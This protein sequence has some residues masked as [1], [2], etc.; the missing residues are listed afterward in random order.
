MNFQDDIRP[1][2]RLFVLLLL[3]L[4][5][6][7][8]AAHAIIIHGDTNRDGRLDNADL[9]DHG[10]WTWQAGPFVLANLDDDDRNGKTDAADSVVNGPADEKDLARFQIIPDVD[11]IPEGA[12]LFLAAGPGPFNVFRKDGSRWVPVNAETPL[13]VDGAAPIELGVEAQTFAGVK[14]WTGVIRLEALVKKGGAVLDSDLAMARV[15]PWLMFPNSAPTRAFFIATGKYDNA[16]MLK[17]TSG[18]LSRWGV[19]FP[20]PHQ[21]KVWQ[22]MWMQDSLEIGY[23]E[24]PGGARMHVVLNGIRGADSFGPTLLAPD[25]GV[26][27]VGGNRGMKGHDAWVDWYGNLEVSHPTPQYPFGRIYYGCNT[28][29]GATLHP[30]V[31]RF[32]EAQVLQDPFWVDTSWL[33]IKHVDEIFNVIPGRDGQGVVTIIQPRAAAEVLGEPLDAFNQG[34]QAKLDKM[35]RGGAYVINGRTVNYPGI[36]ALL[37]IPANRFLALPATYA[38]V[39]VESGS[40]R[41]GAH[42]HWSNPVNSVYLN[43]NVLIGGAHMPEKIKADIARRFQSV[44]VREVGFVDDQVYQD[45][46]GTVHCSSNTLKDFPAQGFWTRFP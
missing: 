2:L 11:G 4:G 46:W 19:A 42:N 38:A 26:V 1:V 28:D 40:N 10:A 37:G 43:G 20:T 39:E 27:V 22:E 33:A 14:G 15:A 34:I 32:L 3:V 9:K 8:Q 41:P 5:V 7:V 25:L 45:R 36:Q 29:T 35:V 24:I 21:A 12:Q 17:Q 44:G 18:F 16:A 13:T 31:V 6:N 30:E 23:T